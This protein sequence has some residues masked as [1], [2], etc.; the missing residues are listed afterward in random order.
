MDK[1]EK[2]ECSNQWAGS[3]ISWTSKAE[4]KEKDER[5]NQWTSTLKKSPEAYS[6]N[7]YQENHNKK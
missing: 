6:E 4:L 1:K 5:N 7:C 2:C 3:N